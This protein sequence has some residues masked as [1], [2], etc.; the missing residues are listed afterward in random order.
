MTLQTD[1]SRSPYFD[2][3]NSSKNF[4]RV[5]YRPSVAVQTRELNQMQ[6]ILQD[7]IDKF[8][9]HIFKEGSVIEGCSFTFDAS[10]NY[11]KI[12]DNYANG[13]AF[14]ISDFVN[15]YITNANGLKALIVNSQVGYQSQDPD[16]NTLYIKYLNTGSFANG[17]SQSAFA[18]AEILSISTSASVAIGNVTVATVTNSTGSG[19]AFTTTSGT[20]F[21]KGFFVTVNPQT[22]VVSKY[23]NQPNNI[24]VGFNTVE[25]II[26]PEADSSLYDNAAGAPNYA[27]PGAHRLQLIPTLVT[28]TTS[29]IANT[30]S[31]FS[32]CDFKAGK[33]VSIKNDPQYATLGTEFA[34]RTYETSG[35]YVVYPF[36]LTT[37]TKANT[38]T[39]FL[40]YNNLVSSPGLGYV[41][42]YRVEYINSNKVP[43]RKGTDYETVSSQNV[44]ANFG[45]YIQVQEY[46]GEFDS[47]DI[48]Q[49]EL[50]NRT[51]SAVSGGQRLAVAYSA[52]SLIGY[53][54]IRGFVYQS[55]LIGSGSDLYNLYLFD[56]EMLPGKN[57]RDVKSV[58]YYDGSNQVGVADVKLTYD[59]TSTQN[60]AKIQQT[61]FNNMVFP[62]GQKG[63][64]LNGFNNTEYVYRDKLSAS[65][66]TLST[67]SMTVSL[68]SSPHGT[69]SESIYETGT[70]SNSSINKFIIVAKTAG[71]TS[72]KAGTVAGT[73][74]TPYIVG[75]G[76]AFLS[77]YMIGD[78]ITIGSYTYQISLISDNT[79]ITLTSNL[80]SS[81]SGSSHHKTFPAGI[82]LDF[83]KSNGVISRSV[84][85]TSTSIT[86]TLG[87]TLGASF[88]AFV[89]FDTLRSSTKSISKNIKRNVYVTI[90]C[91]SHSAGTNGPW[92]LGA[93][94]VFQINNIY[95]TDNSFAN[96]G[97]DYTS[98]FS[99]DNGQR[100]AYYG[101]ASIK[102]N[103][104]VLTTSSRILVDMDVFTFNTDSGVGFFTANSYPV[105]D[106]NG[107]SNTN[108]ITTQQIPQYIGSDGSIYDLR[109]SVD[110][111]PFVANT[112]TL[113]SNSSNWNTTT[114]TVNP[115]SALTFS[116]ISGYGSYLPTPDSNF[117]SDIQH[118]LRRKDKAVLGTDGTLLVIEGAANNRPVAPHDL[119]SFM[120]LGIIDVPPY[121]SLS[122]A[123]AAAAKRYD[124]AMSVNITQNKRYTMK[125]IGVLANKIDNLE[126]Y[127]SLSLLEKSA[128][129]TLVRSSTTG[130]NRFQNGILVDPFVGH[131]IGNVNDQSYYISIDP[132]SHLR[133]AFHQFQ[134]PLKFDE[135]E[136]TNVVRKGNAVLLKYDSVPYITQGYA[137]KY[138]NCVDGNIFVWQAS[139]EFN[140]PGDYQP[141][142]TKSP[143]VVNN[144]DLASNFTAIA[145]AF[146]TQWGNWGTTSVAS[147]TSGPT[148]TGTSQTTDAKGNVYDTTKSQTVTTTNVNQQRVG[149][150]LSV[151]TSTTNYNLG[152]FVTDVS[153]LPYVRAI[154]VN[155]RVIG[156]KPKT[157]V[158]CFMANKDVNAWVRQCASDGSAGTPTYDAN[159]DI[160]SGTKSVGDPIITDT[161]G[162]V[163]I[164]YQIPPNTFQSTQLEM[165]IVDVSDLVTGA[166]AI[167]TRAIGTFYGSNISTAKGSSI[168]SATQATVSAVQV[169]Q[170]QTLTSE[171]VNPSESTVF[172]HGPPDPPWYPP[173]YGGG[174][175]GGAW[176][177]GWDGG[178][179]CGNGPGAG[180]CGS[181]PDSG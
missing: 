69:A 149:T 134:R 55:G 129:D 61:Q 132:T 81:P 178:G 136:S 46:C 13:T 31:F 95:V 75:T 65:F 20:I 49:V 48:V 74:G 93:A 173:Y 102:K 169:V 59:A 43:I 15:N 79:H 45:Y 89:Y 68:P 133:P 66:S 84:V 22:L 32:L 174:D 64:K 39:R 78:Y 67:G 123:D 117:Q 147:T 85:A 94:D 52:T 87:E 10:Y 159:G 100:D 97:V 143:D 156:M 157:R 29:D 142:V 12:N 153:I 24:S 165:Q 37:E 96:S 158:Y 160:T 62:F 44:T 90:N 25:N 77:D 107:A 141:D 167:T 57:F 4:Y 152:T 82:P 16:L 111:R 91:A 33:P 114:P 172:V 148:V 179:G 53:A 115:S 116:I 83:T 41:K 146:G 8:G 76:S 42:G 161:Q 166:N 70:L 164:K 38:D 155:I 122:T 30:E 101:L 98:Q 176:S 72:N 170:Q 139:I 99:L 54:Y 105:D 11:V 14:T 128:K 27:A 21:Q 126:Y 58:I 108:A 175:G 150:Q 71:A 151:A 51:R 63:L 17:S 163:F 3:Y 110:F 137:S 180:A 130:Q 120:T 47:Y 124:Y 28:T 56:V 119:P 35:D 6:T 106:V 138:R 118:Y 34:R 5:L 88:Q 112:A 73:S 113:A 1:L 145:A 50:H 86:F 80:S 162:Q 125:D 104:V 36:V 121:P 92:S 18:N 177:T 131:D 154:Q 171:V 23:S 168:L 7:Q 103:G 181:G 26:T 60:V 2:D 9:R 19:Y 109:D 135:A 140:P 144:I 127:T 40:N